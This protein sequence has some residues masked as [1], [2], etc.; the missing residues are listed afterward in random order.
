MR[1]F[2]VTERRNRLA[3]RHFLAP[4][5]A[6][7]VLP[8]QTATLI[9]WHA[10]DPATPYLS[11]WARRAGFEPGASDQVAATERGRLVA[12]VQKAELT[13][14]LGDVRVKPRF[15]SPLSKS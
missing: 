13:E 3:Y 15:P 5:A 12:D 10:T 14:W 7:P 11:L 6:I 9:G 8:A 1:T 2:A 4:D